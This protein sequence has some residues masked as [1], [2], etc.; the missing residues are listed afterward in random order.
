MHRLPFSALFAT[1]ATFCSIFCASSLQAQS[2]TE[3]EYYR[4]IRLPIPEHIVLEAGALEFLPDGRLAIG[5][6][7]GE[8][9]FLDNPL[10]EK[11]EDAFYFQ[12]ARG[13]HE[14][15]GLAWRD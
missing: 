11:P 14:I 5:T 12:F 7:R 13:L 10:S 2:P 15:L 9:Y 1:F 6:R 8:I 3:E 4:M